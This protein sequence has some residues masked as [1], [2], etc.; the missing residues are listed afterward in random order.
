MIVAQGLDLLSLFILS[1]TVAAN[2]ECLCYNF[3]QSARK[4][5]RRD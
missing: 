3:L 5:R 4:V 1:P 2:R